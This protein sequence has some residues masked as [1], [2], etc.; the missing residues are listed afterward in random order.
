MTAAP[1]SFSP[2][3]ATA[4][5]LVEHKHFA[6]HSFL[7]PTASCVCTGQEVA[8]AEFSSRRELQIDFLFA[9]RLNASHL[10][11]ATSS[12]PHFCSVAMCKPAAQFEASGDRDESPPSSPNSTSS[13]EFAD[14]PGVY[15][16]SLTSDSSQQSGDQPLPAHRPLDLSENG[17]FF[18]SLNQLR[19]LCR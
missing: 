10:R 2:S 6:A 11:V 5:R 1:R 8:P 16:F 15:V 12:A 9:A 19:F 3:R 17:E 14:R 4:D 7:F 18:P 13:S